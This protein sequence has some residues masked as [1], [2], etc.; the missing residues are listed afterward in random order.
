[1]DIAT[2][3]GIL[4][5]LA[6]IGYPVATGEGAEMFLH[7]LSIGI[8]FGGTIAG[9]MIHFPMDQFLRIF[10]LVRK[11]IFYKAT[12]EDDLI[13]KMMN[14]SAISRRDG[15]LALQQQI[16]TA[17][18]S[19][20]VKAVQ[21][22]VD[23]QKAEQI[24]DHLLMEIHYLSERHSDGK[25]MLEFMAAA[26]PGF[27]MV[28]TLMGLV[29]MLAALDSPDKIGAGMAVALVATFYG[30]LLA[31]FIFIPL[32]GKLGIRSKQE[33]LAREMIMHGTLSIARGDTPTAV[34]ERMQAFISAKVREDM[35][36][37]IK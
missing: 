31:N 22:L 35:K 16:A 8:V 17:G 34:K 14:Y 3:I 15:V 24:E 4:L 33:K 18:D 27:G 32:A 7:M 13:Q 12:K 30:A 29:Q 6:L 25:K 10:T 28:A 23:G 5:G 21:M 9:T 11:T 1:M 36:P 37:T 19:F 26:A 20:L 2:I